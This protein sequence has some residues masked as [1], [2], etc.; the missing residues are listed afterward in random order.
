LVLTQ[1]DFTTG[2]RGRLGTGQ[3]N[4]TQ[5]V[6]WSEFF[7]EIELV[8]SQVDDDS[9][10]L[11]PDKP[12]HPDGFFLTSKILR[13]IQEP[14]PAGAP[15]STP[16]RNYLKAWDNV[17]V[18]KGEVSALQC[19]I[20]TYDSSSDQLYAYGE[21]DREVALVQ[22]KGAGQ[23]PSRSSARA[24][25]YNVKTGAGYSVGSD[26]VQVIDYRTG[27]R[28]GHVPPPD[29]N[30]KPP[31]KPKR[32]YKIPQTNTERKGFTGF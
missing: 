6:R 5:Q 27:G 19:D 26:V 32:L 11:N 20:A 25:Q 10:T 12:L 8:R 28:P 3:A 31:K 7:G 13:V 2:M 16:A 9:V 24:V 1:I 29:P 14:P 22:Q 21:G 23:P 4:D 18:N 30:A 17:T 15:T